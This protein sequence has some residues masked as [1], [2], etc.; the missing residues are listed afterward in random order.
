MAFLQIKPW[1][2]VLNP[3]WG[4]EGENKI[5]KEKTLKLKKNSHKM[6]LRRDLHYIHTLEIPKTLKGPSKTLNPN[7]RGQCAK[8]V[9]IWTKV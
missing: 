6:L 3:K 9:H 7:P 5:Q 8:T 2:R 4:S 1:S